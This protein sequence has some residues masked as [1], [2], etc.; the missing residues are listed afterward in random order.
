MLWGQLAP[1]NQGESRDPRRQRLPIGRIGYCQYDASFSWH[2]A[3]R[4]E[5]RAYATEKC[6]SVPGRAYSCDKKII[7]DIGQV[8]CVWWSSFFNS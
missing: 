8:R 7:G 4:D 5:P 2:E 6:T 3:E 1:Q